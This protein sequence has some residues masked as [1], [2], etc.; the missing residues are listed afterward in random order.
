MEPTNV[1]VGGRFS[2]EAWYE[3]IEKMEVTVWYS[4]PTAF[5]MLMGAGD[6]LVNKYNLRLLAAYFKRRGAVKSRSH[7]VGA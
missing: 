7:Q 1:V 5:R 6:D 2:P 4:A 3:T